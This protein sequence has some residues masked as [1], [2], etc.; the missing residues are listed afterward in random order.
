MTGCKIKT[1]LWAVICLMGWSGTVN[2]QDLHFLLVAPQSEPAWQADL[3]GLMQQAA[4]TAGLKLEWHDLSKYRSVEKLKAKI[5]AIRGDEADRYWF[6]YSGPARYNNEDLLEDFPFF[7][8][9]GERIFLSQIHHQLQAAAHRLVITMVDGAN[10]RSGLIGRFET[11][12]DLDPKRMRNLL[13]VRGDL[14]LTGFSR[15]QTSSYHPR[16]GGVYSSAF[17]QALQHVGSRSCAYAPIWAE[18]LY[19]A[20]HYTREMLKNLRKEQKSYFNLNIDG[21]DFPEGI[22]PH[23]FDFEAD[24]RLS[25]DYALPQ[26]PLPPPRPSARMGL[27]Q[28]Y[29][30]GSR[31]LGDVD[32]IL[33]EAIR[34]CG[35]HEKSYYAV[36]EGFALATIMEQMDPATAASLPPPDRWEADVSRLEDFDLLKYLQALVF[37]ETGSFRVFVFVVTPV[38]FSTTGSP[39]GKEEARE[40]LTSGMNKLPLSL[41]ELPFTDEHQCTVLIYEF[42]QRDNGE[43]RFVERS[44]FP[45]QVH[46]ER[47]HL[48]DYLVKP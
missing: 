6:Y 20:D 24:R 7:E 36:P 1:L 30:A 16:H 48:L 32:R 33:N 10:D 21:H 27:P 2:G 29:F 8:L 14:L 35:Y 28:P 23:G 15:Y 4:R 31:T 46:L 12:N 17:F 9:G 42:E 19:F 11:R 44:R 37:G 40:W 22:P 5:D 18:V 3:Q 38:A 25:Y 13:D 39:V 47:A 43:A 45:S 34:K 41:R 26:F